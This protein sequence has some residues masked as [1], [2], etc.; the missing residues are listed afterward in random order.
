[1]KSPFFIAIVFG[2]W[3]NFYVMASGQMPAPPV[4]KPPVAPTKALAVK[5]PFIIRDRQNRGWGTMSVGGLAKATHG[6]GAITGTASAHK[7]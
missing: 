5:N 3:M 7:H 2:V 4:P 6:T 1:M